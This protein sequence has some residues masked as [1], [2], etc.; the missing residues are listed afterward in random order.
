MDRG[1]HVREGVSVFVCATLHAMVRV[2]R[3]QLLDLNVDM[4]VSVDMNM[5]TTLKLNSSACS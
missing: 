5:D 2:G 4:G 1:A 3:Y